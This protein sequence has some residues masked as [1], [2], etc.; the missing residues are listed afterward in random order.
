MDR[1]P[2]LVGVLTNDERSWIIQITD[3]FL[4][5]SWT[6]SGVIQ[7]C[8]DGGGVFSDKRDSTGLRSLAKLWE[9]NVGHWGCY[10]LFDLQLS[11]GVHSRVRGAAAILA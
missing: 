7:A 1:C 10:V 11:N 2:R 3:C 6:P 9:V 5:A 4:L 8:V